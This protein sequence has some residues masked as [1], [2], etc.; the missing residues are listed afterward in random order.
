MKS[1]LRRM[2]AKVWTSHRPPLCTV[3]AQM[4]R[5][6]AVRCV[7]AWNPL[8]SLSTPPSLHGCCKCGGGGV[9]ASAAV[10]ALSSRARSG[11]ASRWLQRQRR[12]PFVRSAITDGFASRAAY[13]LLQLDKVTCLAVSWRGDEW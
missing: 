4:Q 13:K 2:C 5:V 7:G 10:R 12:D 3:R 9:A 6:A 11:S 8:H 1:E